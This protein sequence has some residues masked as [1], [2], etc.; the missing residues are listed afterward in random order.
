MNNHANGVKLFLLLFLV[1]VEN[2]E[3][4]NTSQTIGS[5]QIEASFGKD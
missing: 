3:Q 4:S 2:C 5:R 1:L